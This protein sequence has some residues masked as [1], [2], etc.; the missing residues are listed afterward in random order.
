M[1]KKPEWEKLD[2]IEVELDGSE[3]SVDIDKNLKGDVKV[4]MSLDGVDIYDGTETVVIP[5][6]ETTGILEPQTGIIN[7]DGGWD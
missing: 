7:I 6:N 3:I 1:C 5:S 2:P 4:W